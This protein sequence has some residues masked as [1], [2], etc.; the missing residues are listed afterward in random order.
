DRWLS[1]L[2]A[3]ES[4]RRLARSEVMRGRQ[5]VI[6]GGALILSCVMSVFSKQSCLVSEDDIL[7]GLAASLSDG[8]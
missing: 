1:V 5:D 3:E 2:A 7:D 4:A 6:V 8:R